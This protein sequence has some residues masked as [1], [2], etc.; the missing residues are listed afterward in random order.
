V[1]K[2]QAGGDSVGVCSGFVMARFHSYV[3]EQKIHELY[4]VNACGGVVIA[5]S[6]RLATGKILCDDESEITSYE[7][8]QA[9]QSSKNV[10]EN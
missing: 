4:E 10:E 6:S 5:P 9:D 1:T 8:L 3:W 7:T 2:S